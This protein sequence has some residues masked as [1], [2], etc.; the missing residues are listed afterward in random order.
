VSAQPQPHQVTFISPDEGWLLSAQ[1]CPPDLCGLALRHTTDGGR[2]WIPLPSLP[3]G[4]DPYATRMVFANSQVGYLFGQGVFYLT[5]DGAMTWIRQPGDA[6]AI[7]V[8]DGTALRVS[9]TAP[10]CQPPGCHYQISTA[11]VGTGNWRTVKADAGGGNGG[12]QLVRHGHQAILAFYGNLAG[13]VSARATLLTSADDGLTWTTRTDPCPVRGGPGEIDASQ[14][15]MAPDGSMTVFCYSRGGPDPAQAL[16]ITSRDGGVTFGP[17][18]VAPADSYGLN[19]V[20]TVGAANATMLFVSTLKD[21]THRLFRSTDAGAT[22]TPVATM[23]GTFTNGVLATV[24]T[25]PLDSQTGYWLTGQATIF[26]THDA[27]QHWSAQVPG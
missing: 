16:L 24:V 15:S 14:M 8:A 9:Y 4:I 18:Q 19:T 2:T 25:F 3:T 22:W 12:P 10:G 7:D 21:Q 20:L 23:P 11:A 5:T 17:P 6:E 1:L 13:G 26:V 27:G